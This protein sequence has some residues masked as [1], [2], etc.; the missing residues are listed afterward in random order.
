MRPM[1]TLLLAGAAIAGVTGL[2]LAAGAPPANN[3][4]HE[5]TV[6]LPNGSVAHIRYTGDVAPKLNFIQGPQSPFAA[7]AFGGSSPFDEI[8]RM[9]A[10]MDRQMAAVML[11]ARLMQR[12]A[13]SDPLFHARLNSAGNG[14]NFASTGGS[15]CMRSVQITATPNGGAPKIVS[16]TE[17]NCGD[18]KQAAPQSNTSSTSPKASG[19]MEPLQ[20]ISYHPSRVSPRSHSGI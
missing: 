8:A 18:A 16:H 3:A 11:Q 1:T 19:S 10:L 7:A 2:A 6:Q 9:Q 17:G 14:T 4:V 12:A 15:F 20:T 5:M 13:M